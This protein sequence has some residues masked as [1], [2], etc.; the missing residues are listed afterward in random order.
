MGLDPLKIEGGGSR[1]RR[2]KA[3]DELDIDAIKS[4]LAPLENDA[5]TKKPSLEPYKDPKGKWTIGTGHLIG[6]EGTN[7][8]LAKSNLRHGITESEAKVLFDTDLIN[9]IDSV[10]RPDQLG[11][12]FYSYSPE[13]KNAIISSYFRGDL[14]GSPN[15]KAALR[16]G[17]FEGAAK[18]LLDNDS[19]RESKNPEKPMGGITKRFD[20]L[21]ALF[22]SEKERQQKM[23]QPQKT[24]DDGGSFAETVDGKIQKFMQ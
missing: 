19:Y 24:I 22:R 20:E 4:Y 8:D 5:I 11:E 21:A 23:Q 12:T 17:D 16:A 3:R 7:A 1:D 13:L 14:S 15:A 2:L 9:K 6:K 18:N 10:T